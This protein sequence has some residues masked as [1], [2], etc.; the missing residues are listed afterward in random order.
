V[1]KSKRQQPIKINFTMQ[2]KAS[3]LSIHN[4]TYR[5][6][7]LVP[8]FFLPQALLARTGKFTSVP[9]ICMRYLALRYSMWFSPRPC[10]F[11]LMTLV[12]LRKLCP[13][14][15]STVPHFHPPYDYHRKKKNCLYLT[16][17][18]NC[19]NKYGDFPVTST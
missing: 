5:T 14:F 6:L 2:N 8:F 15:I 18:V 16:E 19:S 7:V 11:F 9:P 10:E 3:L 12:H 4:T 1:Q 17:I 13:L